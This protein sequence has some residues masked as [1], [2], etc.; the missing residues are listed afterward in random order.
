MTE[1]AQQL[2]ELGF[3]VSKTTQGE[4]PV[5]LEL[6]HETLV[7]RLGDPERPWE[8]IYEKAMNGHT[9]WFMDLPE[10]LSAERK[11]T[12]VLALMA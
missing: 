8:T 1:F 3:R 4:K 11:V 6:A 7:V 9:D 12:V 5:V 10:R 2:V